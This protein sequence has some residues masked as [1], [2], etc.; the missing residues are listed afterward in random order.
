M[1]TPVSTRQL[2]HTI[3][4][5]LAQYHFYLAA[6]HDAFGPAPMPVYTVREI[7]K[8]VA[9]NFDHF[10]SPKHRQLFIVRF[11][12]THE[13]EPTVAFYVDKINFWDN[14]YDSERTV[15]FKLA[16]P[17]FRL[18]SL[19]EEIGRCL[20]PATEAF[21]SPLLIAT[22]SDMYIDRLGNRW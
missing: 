7:F 10:G 21:L 18:T 22:R 12:L 2:A 1:N 5:E 17:D 19:A 4:N 14:Y 9:D 6:E 15:E 11:P 20:L 13:R 8:H 16:D 3:I